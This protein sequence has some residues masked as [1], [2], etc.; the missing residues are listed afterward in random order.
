MKRSSRPIAT[1]LPI[2]VAALT[3]FLSGCGT[4]VNRVNSQYDTTIGK[5]R[6][7]TNVYQRSVLP[8]NLKRVAVL[9]MHKGS[10]GHLE[11]DLIEE[12]FRLELV[13]RNLFEVVKV[14]PETMKEMFSKERYSS[15]EYLPT[16]L[17]ANLHSSIA[18][19][20]ILLLDVSYFNAYQ[21]VG[22]G[23]RAKLLDGNT[24][25]VVWAADEV[26]DASNPEVSNAARKYYKTESI[27]PYPLQ[28]TQ[29][30]LHSP[31]RFSKYVANSLFSAIYL[32]NN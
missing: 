31:N 22:L 3:I 10:Y 26:F 23:I 8:E 30:V 7:T 1:G 6:K 29:T 27:I 20:G 18:I 13:K 21:P 25:E 28:S 14:S 15:V 32:Q 11:M 19:D 9:P 16:Q 12:N 17:I 2:L 5:K 4:V 24:G